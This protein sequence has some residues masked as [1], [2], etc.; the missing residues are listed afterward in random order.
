MRGGGAI[1]VSSLGKI[2]PEGL[3]QLGKLVILRPERRSFARVEIAKDVLNLIG[4]EGPGRD[5]MEGISRRR[6]CEQ[7]PVD[8]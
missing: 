8:W 5:G 4:V 7:I 3:N 1:R 2:R 6:E